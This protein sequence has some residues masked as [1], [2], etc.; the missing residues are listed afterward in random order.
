MKAD[1]E[2]GNRFVLDWCRWVPAKVNIH[3]WRAELDRLPTGEA[4]LKRNILIEESECPFC[5]AEVESSEHL[6]ISCSTAAF[7][8]QGVSS[9]CKI[10]NIFAFS[11]SDL[12]SVFK[13]LRMSEKK[14]KEAI[15]CVIMIACWSLWRA[16]NNVR[17][18]NSPVKID[19]ILSE[20]KAL[21]YLWFSHRSR[22]KGIEWREWCSFINM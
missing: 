1:Q 19:G 3:V 17:F 14:K 4:L 20:V 5:G 8:W 15:Q 13:S 9:W 6:F 10:P 21:G 16:R 18:L 22:F 2:A 11:I 12:L 7:V